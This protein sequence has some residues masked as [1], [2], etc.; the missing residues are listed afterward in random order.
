MPDGWITTGAHFYLAH[1]FTV[2]PSVNE[3]LGKLGDSMREPVDVGLAIVSAL[4]LETLPSVKRS[5][6]LKLQA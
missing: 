3:T 2:A 4:N 5:P 1:D 6:P